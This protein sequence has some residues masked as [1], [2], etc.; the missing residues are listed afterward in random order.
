MP[1]ERLAWSL[2]RRSQPTQPPIERVV[3][4]QSRDRGCSPTI[5]LGQLSPQAGVARSH[6][7][8]PLHVGQRLGRL[9]REKVDRDEIVTERGVMRVRGH[10]LGARPNGVV[11]R[12]MGESQTETVVRQVAHSMPCVAVALVSLDRRLELSHGLDVITGF[13]RGNPVSKMTLGPFVRHGFYQDPSSDLNPAVARCA[14]TASAPS[15]PAGTS[16]GRRHRRP[17]G[18]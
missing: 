18:R 9:P 3:A 1:R 14:G 15:S 13:Q 4:T 8:A 2:D 12:P 17:P 5:Q 16:R 11:A 7:Q 6:S 10:R